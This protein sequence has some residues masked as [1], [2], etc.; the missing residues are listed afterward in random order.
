MIE[1]QTS[2]RLGERMRLTLGMACVLAGL[3]AIVLIVQ[4]LS[5]SRTAAMLYDN[6][7]RNELTGVLEQVARD[8]QNGVDLDLHD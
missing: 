2:E 5:G 1:P 6:E 8:L 3:S 4:V 7:A